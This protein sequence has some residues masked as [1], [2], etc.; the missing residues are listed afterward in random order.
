L[1][2]AVNAANAAGGVMGRQIHLEVLGDDGLSANAVAQYQKAES[3]GHIDFLYPGLTSGEALAILPQATAH[4]VF[5]I[6]AAQASQLGS[7]SAFPNHFVTGPGTDRFVQLMVQ[8]LKNRGVDHVALL[9]GDDATGE[10]LRKSGEKY[11]ADAGISVAGTKVYNPADTDLTAAV[12]S[13]KATG[14]S[15]LVFEG[16]GTPVFNVLKAVDLIGWNVPL[17]GGLTTSTAKY[18]G[19]APKSVLDRMKIWTW[20]V[21]TTSRGGLPESAF[22]PML[23]GASDIGFDYQGVG[24]DQ[25]AMSLAWDSIWLW[26]S[27]A[28][29]AKSF[30]AKAISKV[31]RTTTFRKGTHEI[32]SFDY[33]YSSTSNL[34]EG[35]KDTYT[36]ATPYRRDSILIT[37]AS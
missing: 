10:S 33:K 15:S 32:L 5:S 34:V 16:Q 19:N 8:S 29:T 6:A 17:Y 20:S 22:T 36:W 7:P 1:K 30:D 13:L 3:E 35:T 26:K 23:K 9:Y 11:F 18:E 25:G 2:V 27:A 28:E 21:A 37:N 31:L 12:S 24:S 4:G 14:A